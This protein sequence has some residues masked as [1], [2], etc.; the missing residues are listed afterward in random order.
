MS[1]HLLFLLTF[2][3][4]I[5]FR[6]SYDHPEQRLWF[7]TLCVFSCGSMNVFRPAREQ[8]KIVTRLFSG[9]FI[10]RLHIHTFCSSYFSL[11]FAWMLLDGNSSCIED[12]GS[13]WWNG[14]WAPSDDYVFSIIAL[15]HQAR[16]LYEIK[17]KLYHLW[18]AISSSTK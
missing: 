4:H 11:S 15:N 5:K 6:C 12:G 2:K 8:H 1:Q 13:L 18:T 14:I 16:C 17:I 9:T 10:K 7:S 3:W